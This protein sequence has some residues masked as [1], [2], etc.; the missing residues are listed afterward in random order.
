M[1]T[2]DI[3]ESKLT[4]IL[5]VAGR[6]SS[7]F[8]SESTSLIDDVESVVHSH[9]AIF[10]KGTIAN[11]DYTYMLITDNPKGLLEAIVDRLKS[12]NSRL[13]Q[14]SLNP[15]TIIMKLLNQEYL[16]DVNGTRLC[17]A[18]KSPIPSNYLMKAIACK[19]VYP[20]HLFNSYID[21]VSNTFAGNLQELH[22]LYDY[23]IK[24]N[25]IL[26]GRKK[27]FTPNEKKKSN[28]RLEV[29][30]KLFEYVRNAPAVAQGIIFINELGECNASA[31]NI[32]FTEIKYRNAII[33][34]LKLLI[35]ESYP[36]YTFKS[37]LHADFTVP[38]DFRMRKT[39]CI[40]ND[41]ESKQATYIANI[42]NIATYSPVPCTRF[43]IK[44]SFIYMAHPIMKLMLLYID[45]YMIEHKTKTV[46][47][48]SHEQVYLNKMLQAYNELRTFDKTPI[49]V[50]VFIDEAYE[51]I[52]Y[53]MRMK[54]ANP[55]D[56]ILI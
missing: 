24:G 18:I 44:E 29:I 26:G 17:Y 25:R 4:W 56:T 12:R 28:V 15:I 51:R 23:R 22:P 36:T 19:H 10:A 6:V 5:Q 47:P 52:K 2:I 35:P 1:R 48:T 11:G 43:I 40:M 42:Y 33:D 34:Y 39:S 16:F 37:F 3:E 53:N 55:I 49:W 41:I 21:E 27:P 45:M 38:Y 46:N 7:Y 8:K 32:L 9:K 31:V 30:S 14:T 50:G 13:Y 54:M 20:I